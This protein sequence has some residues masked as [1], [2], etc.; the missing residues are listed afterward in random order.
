M[1]TRLILFISLLTPL[2]VFSQSIEYRNYDWESNTSVH[3]LCTGEEKEQAV[4]L[5]D[6]RAIEYIYN[7]D[8]D[9]EKYY[10]RHRIVHLNEDNA[11]K[12]H[13]R[14]YLPV[15]DPGNLLTIKARSVTKEGKVT[16][17]FKGNMK[18]INE[19]GS[20]YLILAVEGLEKGGE[21][22]YYYTMKL[23]P[24]YFGTETFQS[25]SITKNTELVLISPRNLVFETRSYNKFPEAKEDT[26]FSM[27]NVL[28][29]RADSIPPLEEEKYSAYKASL[30]RVDYKLAKNTTKGSFRVLTWT[31]AGKI[32]YNLVHDNGKDNAKAAGKLYEKLR[33]G[34]I[35]APEDRI[36]EIENYIKSNINIQKGSVAQ[37]LEQ[38]LKNHIGNEISVLTLF[39]L[40]LEK[41]GIKYELAITCDRTERVFDEDFDT[42]DD[43]DEYLLYFPDYRKY[44][45]S[46]NYSYRY[47]LI[48]YT[49]TNNKALFVKEVSIGDT[50]SALTSIRLIPPVP[51]EISYD[52]LDISVDLG[53][54]AEQARFHVK[55]SMNGYSA[56]NVR[57]L[58]FYSNDENK[59]DLA[60]NVL[61]MGITDARLENPAVQNFNLA[62]GDAGKEFIMEG[63]I[64]SES[65]IE[66][67]ND[68]YLFKIGE[69]IG[70]QEELYQEKPR[71]NP[72]NLTYTHSYLRTISVKIPDGYT[73]RG[74][75]KL[76][77]SVVMPDSSSGFI[78][79]YTLKGNELL[80]SAREYYGKY[81]YPVD[82][83]A[84]FRKV[85]NAA[86]D[87][88]KIVIVLE[89]K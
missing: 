51:A 23:S 65:L 37:P 47:G 82:Q 10:T 61:K 21:L 8:G 44:L 7:K 11:V 67:T 57:P 41:C 9:L 3:K 5:K 30:M 56:A 59:K 20:E 76:S 83:F 58:Y 46:S 29:A 64:S 54:P 32:Y 50:R 39:A 48:P 71:Q 16:E 18:Q 31:D 33:L 89:K 38:V 87:F 75:E 24:G 68:A 36:R 55:R 88:N 73:A 43:L 28:R 84:G 60:E 13:N 17:M 69:I 19:D 52:N 86:A 1:K 77:M 78:S 12:S 4:V 63:D 45:S 53:A 81:D 6:L 49:L 62:A 35:N 74:A 2:V 66:K 40:L 14:I 72:V 80:V 27:K 42:W 34:N 25:G 22:E 79:T 26:S 15:N 70:P 85:I